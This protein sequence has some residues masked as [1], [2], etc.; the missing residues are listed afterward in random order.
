MPYCTT[1]FAD[2]REPFASTSLCVSATSI[3][4]HLMAAQQDLPPASVPPPSVQAAP[5][6]DVGEPV[7][8]PEVEVQAPAAALNE[9][10]AEVIVGHCFS[11]F[12]AFFEPSSCSLL[13]GFLTCG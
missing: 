13:L 3:K 10:V 4:C 8:P 12:I 11:C 1:S 2:E 6:A 9:Q 5:P 7:H